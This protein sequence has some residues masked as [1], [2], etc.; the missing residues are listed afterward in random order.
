MAEWFSFKNRFHV[1]LTFVYRHRIPIFP[2]GKN[3]ESPGKGT[4]Y[5]DLSYFNRRFNGC[6]SE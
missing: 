1:P 3:F 2:T 4:H 5:H 6:H